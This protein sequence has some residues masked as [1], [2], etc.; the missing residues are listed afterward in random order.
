MSH[1]FHLLNVVANVMD[2]ETIDL[3]LSVKTGSLAGPVLNLS[4]SPVS[5][6]LLVRFVT[7]CIT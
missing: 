5:A 3:T 1:Y 6:L 4:A 7:S 2:S